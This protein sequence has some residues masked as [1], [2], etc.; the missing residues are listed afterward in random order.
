[1]VVMMMVFVGK[2]QAES[3]TILREKYATKLLLTEEEQ[4]Q[5]QLTGLRNAALSTIIQEEDEA[6]KSIANLEKQL[7]NFQKEVVKD[8]VVIEKTLESKLKR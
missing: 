4:L 7:E 5:E 8:A 1:M 2:A 6:V 3:P